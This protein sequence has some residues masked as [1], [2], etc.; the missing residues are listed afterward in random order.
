MV[1]AT[2][3]RLCVVIIVRANVKQ[4]VQ[5]R[6]KLLVQGLAVVHVQES[7][8]PHVLGA[9]KVGAA[10]LVKGLVKG[11][12]QV[13]VVLHVLENVKMIVL[14]LVRADVKQ[15]VVV[16]VRENVK[17][18]AQVVARNHA[19]MVVKVHALQH[20]KTTVLHPAPEGVQQVVVAVV[21]TVVLAVR[22]AALGNV[23][24]SAQLLAKM[25]AIILVSM[26]IV[27]PLA[28]VAVIIPVLVVVKVIAN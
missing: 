4:H 2:D 6:V 3:V 26:I 10:I 24:T 16:L 8:Q 22:E 14:R 23:Y 19:Q 1:N 27:N 25:I 5:V 15:V 11:H 20:V 13:A 7:A 9:A 12:V 21:R 18:H 28:Q 17:T